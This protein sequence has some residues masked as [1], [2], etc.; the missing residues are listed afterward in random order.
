MHD[1]GPE[2]RDTISVRVP[3]DVNQAGGEVLFGT[4]VG[5]ELVEIDGVLFIRDL[6]LNAEP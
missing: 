5:L 3:I 4:I 6:D 2:E 1:A